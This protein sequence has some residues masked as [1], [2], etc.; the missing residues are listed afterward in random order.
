MLRKHG[1]VHVV[2]LGELRATLCERDAEA[3]G[4]VLGIIGLLFN[5]SFIIDNRFICVIYVISV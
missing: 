4:K 5:Q 2:L 3:T 1:H